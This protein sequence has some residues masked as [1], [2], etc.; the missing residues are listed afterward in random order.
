[1]ETKNET[2]I[3]DIHDKIIE[4]SNIEDNNREYDPTDP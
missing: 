4:S 1:M 2:R 3:F